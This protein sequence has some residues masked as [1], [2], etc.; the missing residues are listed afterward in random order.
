MLDNGLINLKVANDGLGLKNALET[1]Y[2]IV[3]LEHIGNF[4][5]HAT[6]KDQTK[7]EVQTKPVDLM[8]SKIRI[9]SIKKLG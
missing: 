8:C 5:F 4:V 7:L 9:V 2:E 1:K 6:C 3:H